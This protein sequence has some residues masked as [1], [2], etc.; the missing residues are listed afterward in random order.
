MGGITKRGDPYLR[1]LFIHG[2]RALIRWARHRN[3]SLSRWIK[4]VIARRGIHKG[5]VAVAHKLA[6]LCWVLLQRQTA[7]ELR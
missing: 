7:F 1:T 2:A 4:A 5:I 6:R 3:D